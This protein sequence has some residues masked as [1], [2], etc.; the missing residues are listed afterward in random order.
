MPQGRHD[1]TLNAGI[2][3]A[4]LQG[5]TNTKFCASCTFGSEQGAPSAVVR[6]RG[7]AADGQPQQSISAS[8][9]VLAGSED[10]CVYVYGLNSQKV[11]GVRG[12]LGP[13]AMAC[14]RRT[15]PWRPRRLTHHV[16][17]LR[18]AGAASGG[19]GVGW[20]GPGAR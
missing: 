14:S 4:F 18:R 12:A 19:Q 2:A 11:R 15:T 9:W 20:V 6:Q 17:L 10:G 3:G 7:A 13:V 5:H 1:S 16:T 8:P